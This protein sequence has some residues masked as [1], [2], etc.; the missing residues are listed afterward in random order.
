MQARFLLGPAGAGKTF[1]CLAE[2]RAALIENPQ[3]P[4]LIFLA[5]KQA[6]YQ[7]ERQLLADPAL[8]GYTRLHIL[9]FERLAGF[10]LKQL[11]RPRP[12]LLSEEGR[13]MVLRALLARRRADLQ[14]FHSSA[15]LAGFARQLSLELREL[16]RREFS[17][18]FLTELAS[19]P[20]FTE[21]LRR[22][23]R[24][25]ALL[26][27]DYLAWLAQQNLQ[28][29][30]YLLDLAAEALRKITTQPPPAEFASGDAPPSAHS[31]D[32]T[33]CSV[34]PAAQSAIRN[35]QSAIRNGRPNFGQ[36]AFAISSLWLDGFGE[37]TPQEL[38]L[39]AALAPCCRKMTLAFCVD[40]ERPAGADSWLSIWSAIAQ[41]RQDCWKKLSTV[42]G[43]RLET[44]ILRRHP[45]SGRFA[46]NPVLRHL[47]ENW[48]QPVPFSDG[49]S[50]AAAPE[51]IATCLRNH[52]KGGSVSAEGFRRRDAGECGRDDRAPGRADTPKSLR[53]LVCANP[54]GEA[55][56]AA[57]EIL[58]FVHAGGRFRQTAVLLRTME[59]YHDVL[60]RVFSRYEIPFF[61]DRR[62]PSAHH[63]L[64]ELTRNALRVTAFD[65]QHD[66]WFSALKTGLI[67]GDEEA[68]DR[69]E[70]EA[71]ARGW[72]GETWT[73]P[74]PDEDGK[75]P[76]A[77]HLRRQWVAPFLQFRKDLST[78]SQLRPDG[79]QL[80]A[81][82][83]AFWRS[84]QVEES[85]AKLQAAP[86][87]PL[88]HPQ[89]HATVWQQMNA[90]LDDVALA[91][92]GEFLP[93]SEWL[94]ILEAGLAGLTVGV[95]PPA[96]DQVLIGTV[97]RSRNPDL[98]LVLLLGLN[99]S[100]FPAPPPPRHLLTESDCAE[101]GGRG[102][103]LGPGLR[104]ILSRERFLGYI[105]CTRA[106]RRLVVSCAQRDADDQPLNPSPFFSHLNRLLPR[107]EIENF[108]GP[109]GAAPLHACELAPRLLGVQ[110][111]GGGWDDLLALPA[112]AALRQQIKL[113][114][115]RPQPER[116][117][118]ALAAQLY[119]PALRTSVSR[120]EQFAACAFR[121]FVNSGLQAEERLL[122]ELDARQKGSFQHLALAQFHEQLRNDHKTW[123]DLTAPEARRRVA[124]ICAALIPQFEAGLLAAEAP[125]R[126]AARGMARALEDFVAAL[127]EW[128]R[129][130]DFEPRAAEVEFGG[131]PDGG[132]LPAWE[133]DLGS[134]QRLVFRGR[135]DRI[136]LCPAGPE[137]LAV[138]M[139][140][141]SSLHKLDPVLM[142]HGLQ[143]QLPAYLSVLR[144]LPDAEKFFGAARLIPAGVFYINLRGNFK[145]GETRHEVLQGR[146]PAWQAAYKHVGRFDLS[147]LPHLDNR[148][149]SRG[150]Q[151]NYRL[152]NDGQPYSSV[153]DPMDHADF[154]QMLDQVEQNLVRMGR[155]IFAGEIAL[156]P[157]QKGAMRA[158]D[159]CVYQGICRIDP[160]SH[161]F[162]QLGKGEA[163]ESAIISAP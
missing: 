67:S 149:E 13:V 115:P 19:R 60:R 43:V 157:F 123:H 7:L 62:E 112:V 59:G 141:K 83:R 25:L 125:S 4:P 124:E 85:L 78:G 61:L 87:G 151:F 126:F 54:E 134:G 3:G 140:Y 47:E 72:K 92:A 5:P 153:P 69:L 65:W 129:Q 127:V 36:S 101:L 35:P 119:G 118:P 20:D 160:W 2:I 71:L 133:L 94:A 116:L 57:G 28:D 147:A 88:S 136:D 159:R 64:A 103:R 143:L 109:G 10:I 131:P 52:P 158:C 48:A 18:E 49:E 113:F 100:V 77:E 97:D 154:Q 102:L 81:G 84:L 135:I 29:A 23:L 53:A 31:A 74:F 146:E 110:D 162:R 89:F 63:P 32:S 37:L 105:A 58:Q 155:A 50:A 70:N 24:D 128:M 138:V 117:S 12:A 51:S 34:A 46:E 114:A 33:T 27:R 161:A 11:G 44:E 150:T 91:F 14:I 145:P 22:K 132:G 76:I 21:P 9:S 79:P 30:D 82:L 106:R 15:G 73:K 17:P 56:L 38:S 98:Q 96:L 137:A 148:G 40:G 80:A 95:I 16:Q 139:D 42:P 108:A 39:L 45:S 41:T 55:V 121:Y 163:E 1:R 6:T 107:L 122:F 26:Q 8:P 156:N 86:E 111:S 93:L 144:R 130:Y 68:I 99:E 142:R 104:Q 152:K 75:T 120:I 66:D 90:W